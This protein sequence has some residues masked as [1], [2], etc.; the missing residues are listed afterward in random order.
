MRH[1]PSPFAN[2]LFLSHALYTIIRIRHKARK[3]LNQMS[4]RRKAEHAPQ[5]AD[6]HEESQRE[7]I[8][9]ALDVMDFLWY[10]TGHERTSQSV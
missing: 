2:T 3:E 10:Y 1:Y 8:R 7:R 4:K 6:E 9:N 5:D